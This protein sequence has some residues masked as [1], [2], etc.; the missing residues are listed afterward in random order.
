MTVK[1]LS[2]TRRAIE[3]LSLIDPFFDPFS[4]LLCLSCPIPPDS[5]TPS[6]CLAIL[7]KCSVSSYL[8]CKFGTTLK[9]QHPY[10][11]MIYAFLCILR[12]VVVIVGYSTLKQYKQ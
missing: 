10:P 9:Y 3:I 11:K 1:A 7:S 5:I 4:N 12:G 2:M 8:Y 6:K